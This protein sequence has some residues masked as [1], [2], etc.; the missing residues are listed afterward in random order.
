MSRPLQSVAVNLESAQFLAGWRAEA[1]SLFLPALSDSRVGDEVAVRIGIFGQTIRATVFGKVSLVRR[2]GRP[3]LP[4]GVELALDRVSLPAARFLATASRGEPVTFRE[5]AP[6]YVQER[7][8]AVS[9]GA[10]TVQA[11]TI[12][13]SEGGCSLA[14]P[15]ELPQAG[16]LVALKLTD[17]LFAPTV[18]AVVCWNALGGPVEK[19]VGLR[20]VVEGRGG[21]A[22]RDFADSVARSGAPVA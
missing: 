5:R 9:A 6:R 22:W 21:R 14:W 4:P 17:G 12:N 1:G 2:V 10:R 19:S 8:L 15:G 13:V 3:S 18:R 7:H 16:D 20:M 11:S